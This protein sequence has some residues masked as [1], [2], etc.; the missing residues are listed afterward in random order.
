M[1]MVRL[2]E[3]LNQIGVHTRMLVVHESIGSPRIESL[4][5]QWRVKS[6]FLAEH[7][8]IFMANGWSKKNLFKISTGRYGMPIH[9]HPWV[10]EADIV[11]LGWVNQGMVSLEEIK[12]IQA[13][14]AWTM[15][16]M[17]NMTGVCHHAG[18]CEHFLK[19]CGDCPLLKYP[20]PNDLSHHTWQQKRALYD[21]KPIHFIAISTWL[22]NKAKESS[23]L[24][25]R[26]VRTI[27][28]P[29]PSD[30]FTGV[31]KHPRSH[32]GL[33]QDKPLIAMGAARLDDPIKGLDLALDALNMIQDTDACAVFFGALRDPNALQSLHLP[34]VWMGPLTDPAAIRDVYA[35]SDIVL[36]SSHYE[37]LPTTLIEGMASGCVAVSFDQGGQTDIIDHLR[38]G[39]LARH[40]DAADLADGLRWAL[41]RPV[42]KA[43]L[44]HEIASKFDALTVAK[45]YAQLFHEM[46]S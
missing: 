29:F 31:V 37:T 12:K 45:H 23:L 8:E 30:Q 6:E 9:E 42:D 14:V 1:V 34:Y 13:P 21:D 27:P 7:A 18:K 5:P 25:N 38:T 15:H 43:V 20:A 35:H 40:L 3:A 44:R 22:R 24:A 41:G 39:Y 19:Q 28:N 33:P 4:K 36:S 2:L 32:Y 46:M 17:W 11:L 10:K 16:D 26:D